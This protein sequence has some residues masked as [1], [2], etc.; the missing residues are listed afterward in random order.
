[1]TILTNIPNGDT[2]GV[3]LNNM[4]KEYDK[5]MEQYNKDHAVC[6]RCGS[7]TYSS[8]LVGYILYMNNKEAYKDENEIECVKCG[9]KG[10]THDLISEEQ[11]KNKL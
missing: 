8:T 1:M 10:I 9:Y 6:P 4:S 3:N 7:N 2:L 11:F 5:F